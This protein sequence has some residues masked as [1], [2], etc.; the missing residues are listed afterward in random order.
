MARGNQRD[1]DRQKA[2]AKDAKKSGKNQKGGDPRA[3]AE[4]WE[5]YT[6]TVGSQAP[7]QVSRAVCRILVE[8]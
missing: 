7:C 1:R 5:L 2:Q 6:R 4:R 8:R 3:R